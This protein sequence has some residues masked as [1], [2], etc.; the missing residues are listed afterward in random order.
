MSDVAKEKSRMPS[1]VSTDQTSLS[2]ALKRWE[3]PNME[4]TG[5]PGRETAFAL[6][7]RRA[8]MWA[9]GWKLWWVNADSNTII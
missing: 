5:F 2:E 4:Q 3:R 9:E 8:N 6:A 1:K 7:P